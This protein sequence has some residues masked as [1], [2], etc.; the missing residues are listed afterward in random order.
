MKIVKTIGQLLLCTKAIHSVHICNTLPYDASSTYQ[1]L[2]DLEF[3]LCKL[4]LDCI[5]I[6][7]Q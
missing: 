1:Q 2:I 3:K 5:E 6:T 7:F 4:L